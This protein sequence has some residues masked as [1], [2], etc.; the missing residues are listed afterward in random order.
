MVSLKLQKRLVASVLKCGKC[1]VWL[2][3]NEVN[4]ISMANSWKNIRKLVKDGLVIQKQTKIHSRAR[5]KRALEAKRKVRHSRYGK[6]RGTMEAK[7]PSKVKGNL[8]KNKCVL[9]SIHKSKAEKAHQKT[10]SDQFEAR[11]A[12]GKSIREQKSAKREERLTQGL[13]TEAT[14]TIPAAVLEA[15]KKSKK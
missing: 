12:K 14:P 5:A 11:R 1:K 10:L 15:T 3:P 7:L 2:D 8:F 9:K 4:K 13:S 6:R